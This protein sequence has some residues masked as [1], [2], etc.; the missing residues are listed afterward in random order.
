MPFGVGPR[1]CIANRFG[2][3]ETKSILYYLLCDFTF[4]KGERSQIPIILDKSG[5][6][7]KA[8]GGCWI[9]LVE[10]NTEE[11]GRQ[12]PTFCFQ[13]TLLQMKIR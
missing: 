4:R 13:F 11:H 1:K 5:F 10:N 8:K 2:L 3:M 7:V 6:Q 12:M 9:K